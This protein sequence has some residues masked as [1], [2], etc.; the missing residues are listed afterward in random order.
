MEAVVAW[1][2]RDS[3]WDRFATHESVLH[4]ASENFSEIVCREDLKALAESGLAMDDD[5]NEI[6]VF[7]HN[8]SDAK[9][10]HHNLSKYFGKSCWKRIKNALSTVL[11]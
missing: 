10:K 1:P 6:L 9:F 7:L 4:G 11:F 3:E 5:E 2:G 8:H